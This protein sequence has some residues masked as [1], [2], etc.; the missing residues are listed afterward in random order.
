MHVLDEN[1]FH[2]QLKKKGY[3]SISQFAKDLRIHRNTIHHYLS[4]VS[5]FP[6]KLDE[7]FSTLGLD[8]KDAIVKK[9]TLIEDVVAPIAQIIDALHARFPDVTFV[10]FGSRIQGTARKYS[11][12]D[13]GVFYRGGISCEQHMKMRILKSDFEEESPYFIDLVNLNEASQEFLQ[14]IARHWIFLTGYRQDWIELNRRAF[15]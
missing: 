15:L 14:N 1:R 3:R 13:L 11:D 4:G 8:F 9:Q 12:W 10:L 2:A 7:I 5:V 6:E